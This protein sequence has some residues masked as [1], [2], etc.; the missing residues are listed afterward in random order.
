M[1]SQTAGIRRWIIREE[2][3]RSKS[4]A[5][6]GVFSIRKE[7]RAGHLPSS[8]VDRMKQHWIEHEKL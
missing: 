2:Q 8:D 3:D 4:R 1:A 6:S 5:S 7:T